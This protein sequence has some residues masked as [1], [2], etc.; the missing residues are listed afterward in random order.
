M[1][2]FPLTLRL[3]PGPVHRPAAW[4][5]AGAD[6][7]VWLSE[8]AV[9][10]VPMTD[11]RFFVVPESSRSRTPIGALVETPAGVAPQ[12]VL[13]AQA[14]GRLADRLFIPAD[15]T[16][17]P[18]VTE[19][20]LRAVLLHEVM[21]LHPSAG[22]I[23]FR[24]DEALSA[25]DL[26]EAPPQRAM[27]WDYAMP[28]GIDRDRLLAVEPAELPGLEDI[29]AS[30]RDDIGSSAPELLPEF[31]DESKVKTTVKW[32]ALT[33]LALAAMAGVSS[34]EFLRAL[35]KLLPRAARSGR[36]G[37]AGRPLSTRPGWLDGLR[38]WMADKAPAI[39]QSLLNARHNELERLRQKLQA[40]PDEGLRYA[41]PLRSL[42][43]RGRAPPG[44]RLSNA[45]RA[46]T[47]PDYFPAAGP[48]TLG[49]SRPT[50]SRA[51]PNTIAKR[52]TGS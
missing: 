17:Q 41:I 5:I 25:H 23:G 13:R 45:I 37:Q 12:G 19:A 20:E 14:Y 33:P 32:I 11:L 9:W 8:V 1:I 4:F 27:S 21:L 18:P 2:Q 39:S 7:G 38:Q 6:P 52:P 31:P 40:D 51:C 35:G 47:S 24:S 42:G 46:S 22:L 29:L 10:C 34:V 50:W 44:A 28:G 43:S 3:L 16:L 36:P 49:R 48:R 26:I 30:S 15:A